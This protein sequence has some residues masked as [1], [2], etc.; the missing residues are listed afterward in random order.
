MWGAGK[1]GV[2]RP[3]TEVVAQRQGGNGNW[4][5]KS[6]LGTVYKDLVRTGSSWLSYDTMDLWTEDSNCLQPTLTSAPSHWRCQGRRA[7]PSAPRGGAPRWPRPARTRGAGPTAGPPLGQSLSPA[8]LFTT[9]VDCSPPGPSVHGDF[10]GKS[11]GVGCH[12]LLQG[13]FPTWWSNLGLLHCRCILY[14][15]SHQG[16]PSS[17]YLLAGF[18]AI[19][20]LYTHTHTHIYIYLHIHKHTNCYS[21]S[22]SGG[23]VSL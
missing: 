20:L 14:R 8:R 4:S 23:K 12:A 10:P 11:T 18:L 21:T 19:Y 2:L 9:P 1:E 3:V 22:K 7:Q 6:R 16:S 5:Q 15:L 13:I 17:W